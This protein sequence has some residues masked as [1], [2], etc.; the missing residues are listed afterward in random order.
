MTD[1]SRRALSLLGTAF[2]KAG[3][4]ATSLSAAGGIAW[5]VW[6]YASPPPPPQLEAHVVGLKDGFYPGISLRQ[7]IELDRITPGAATSSFSD[8]QLNC[9]V[10]YVQVRVSVDG[11]KDHH[12][13]LRWLLTDDRGNTIGTKTS[14]DLQQ[15]NVTRMRDSDIVS[16]HVLLPARPKLRLHV[17][18]FRDHDNRLLQF[19]EPYVT[20]IFSGPKKPQSTNCPI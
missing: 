18:L 9:R 4:I 19:S 5:A 12:V 14:D 10:A 6:H 17:Q 20:P 11:Y 2:T 16:N 3:A 7:F 1:E 15:V 13:W 8:E